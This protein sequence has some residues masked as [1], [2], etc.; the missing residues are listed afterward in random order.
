MGLGSSIR[1]L[2]ALDDWRSNERLRPQPGSAT[3]TSQTRCGWRLRNEAG[4]GAYYAGAAHAGAVALGRRRCR[5]HAVPEPAFVF[6]GRPSLLDGAGAWRIV[7]EAGDGRVLFS[8]R[9]EMA[10]TADGDGRSSFALALAADSD[11]ADA[12]SRIVLTGP[13]GSVAM[14]AGGNPAAA[15]LRDP[16]T[17]RVRGILHDWGESTVPGR[18]RTPGGHC[19]NGDW[20]SS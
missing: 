15:L 14:S 6:D 12:L 4:V 8:Q 11:W 17:G 9:F 18:S 20:K 19:R 5:R 1:A 10:E 2:G 7:G 13:D 3:T 16:A